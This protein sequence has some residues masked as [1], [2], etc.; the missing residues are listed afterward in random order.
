[1]GTEKEVAVTGIGLVTSLGSDV[2]TI[3][4]SLLR[5]DN[6]IKSLDG[7]NQFAKEFGM[8]IAGLAASFDLDKFCIDKK[9][10]KTLNGTDYLTKMLVYA[11]LSSLDDAKIGYPQQTEQYKIG[12]IIG[13][14]T[15]LAYRHDKVPYEER[16]PTWFLDTYPNVPLGVLSIIAAIKGY[17][18]T[19][20]SA[21]TSAN[22]AIGHAFKMIQSGQADVM[23]AGGVDDKFQVPFISGFSRLNMCTKSDNPD[24]AMRPFDK[25]RN[26]FAM[27]Q[28]A[29]VLVL[30]SLSHAKKRG[31]APKGRIVGYGAALNS[32]SV[33]DASSEGILNSIEMA[34]KDAKISPQNIDYINAHGSSTV[35]NDKEESIAIKR[36]FGEK[37][38]QIPINSTKSMVGHTFAACGAI[39]AAVCILSM[40][41]QMVHVTR[42]YSQ[43]DSF[44]DLDYVKDNSRKASIKY[45]LSNTSGI[46]GYNSTLIFGA[47]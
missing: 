25:L 24:T 13:T 2:E 36:L 32:T 39:E 3:W 45:C 8:N 21:C 26:G 1:M 31:A 5:G 27:G 10:K 37:A 34:L 38:Y 19:V 22:Q 17:G 16:N 23:L 30:E 9:G 29:C 47:V 4:N 12:A 15:A 6:G 28:G 46:G 44:C 43:G 42:N 35:S 14:G 40:Q 11:G 7:S 18:C 33:T 41:N 20:V